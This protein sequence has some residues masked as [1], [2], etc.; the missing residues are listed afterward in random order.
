MITM[1]TDFDYDDDF[2]KQLDTYR[3]RYRA[4]FAKV[5]LT[6]IDA[7]NSEL[8]EL[9]K[10]K[11]D[12]IQQ[13]LF[14]SE[15]FNGAHWNAFLVNLHVKYADE[16][17]RYTGKWMHCFLTK[18]LPTLL[19]EWDRTIGPKRVELAHSNLLEWIAGEFVIHIAQRLAY[20]DVLSDLSAELKPT[21]RKGKG[22][23]EPYSIPDSVALLITLMESHHPSGQ[24]SLIDQSALATM[25]ARLTGNT[26]ESVRQIVVKACNES[27]T[28]VSD[29]LNDVK[30]DVLKLK[31]AQPK[32]GFIESAYMRGS[33][34][35]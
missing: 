8:Y 26:V 21:K 4:Q 2:N 29:R 12:T 30:A 19:D 23:L 17:S 7:S 13:L 10:A 14:D 32:F 24:L 34:A 16:H 33:N 20:E 5:K 18:T 3:D 22:Q 28:A 31:L 27:M 11:L 25:I 9:T 35:K 1:K 6:N 15:P